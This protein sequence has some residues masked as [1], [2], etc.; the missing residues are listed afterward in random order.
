MAIYVVAVVVFAVILYV[1]FRSLAMQPASGAANSSALETLLDTVA[2]GT[3]QVATSLTLTEIASGAEGDDPLAAG[4]RSARRRLAGYEQAMARFEPRRISPPLLEARDLLSAGVE[5]L[6][7]ACRMVES[8]GYRESAGLH[9]A[10]DALSHH[11][12][13]CAAE[14]RRLIDQRERK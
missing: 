10:V 5:D 14:A 13:R 7:W 9:D 8:A 4:A 12:R 1:S 2:A 11:A 3:L 6:G